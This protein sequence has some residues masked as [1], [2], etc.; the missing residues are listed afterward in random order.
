MTVKKTFGAG[1]NDSGTIANA[2]R[3]GSER[4][5]RRITIRDRPGRAQGLFMVDAEQVAA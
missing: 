5:V 4:G 2:G 1:N 3:G